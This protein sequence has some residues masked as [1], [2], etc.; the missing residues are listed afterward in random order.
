MNECTIGNT[1]FMKHTLAVVSAVSIVCGVSTARADNISTTLGTAGPSDWAIL[2][3]GDNNV[4]LNGPTPGTVGNVGIGTGGSLSLN[5]SAGPAITGNVTFAG[6]E[7]FSG[8]AGGTPAGQVV[9]IVSA[10]QSSVTTAG[11]TALSAAAAFGS[12]TGLWVPTAT[13]SSVNGN[14]T[15]TGTAGINVIDIG[16]GGINLGNGQELIL[17]GPAGSQFVINVPSITLNSGLI[18]LTG[19]L[20]END[21]VYNVTGTG[22]SVHTAGGL[23]NES[24]IDGIVLDANGAIQMSPGQ[25]NGEVIAGAGIQIVSGGNVNGNTSTVPDGGSSLLLLSASLGCLFQ[26]KKKIGF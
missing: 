11:T 18:A 13:Y 26:L 20:T 14:L 4:T 23:N 1:R 24:V 25:V 19:G 22:N 5:G 8:S 17:N 7:N 3:I 6:S 10:N 12:G 16:T 21:V 15:I 2:S 9:G